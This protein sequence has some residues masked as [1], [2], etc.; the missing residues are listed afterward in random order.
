MEACKVVERFGLDINQVTKTEC[1]STRHGHRI[2]R[3]HTGD[4]TLII[5]WFPDRSSA[6]VEISS[7]SLLRELGVPTLQVYGVLEDALL[8]EDLGSSVRWRPASGNDVAKE[9]VGAAVGRWYKTFHQRG[10]EFLQQGGHGMPFLKRETAS[11]DA[12]TVGEA[13]RALGLVGNP[14]WKVAVDSLHLLKLAE[15]S[16]GVTLC[17][18]DFHW[19]NLALAREGIGSTEAVVYDYH[20]LGVGMPY[21]DYRN[22]AGSLAPEAASAFRDEYGHVDPREGVIDRPLSTIHTL[23]VASRLPQFPHWAQESRDA[24][25][26]GGLLRDIQEA[27]VVAEELL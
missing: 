1:L 18:N 5:K 11:I 27:I 25:M 7:Y 23:V 12:Q 26:R 20:L 14:V 10:S 21:S 2:W 9:E 24:V 15:S 3:V 8:L 13:A 16:L 17:Y 4:G 19:S 6:A 22:V